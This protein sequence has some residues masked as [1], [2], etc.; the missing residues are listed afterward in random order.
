MIQDIGAHKFDLT[1]GQPEAQDHDYVLYMKNNQTLLRKK[2]DSSY[3]IPCF[4]DFPNEKAELKANAYYFCSKIILA[5]ESIE[6][7]PAIRCH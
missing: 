2:A 5:R 1:Y 7:D 3:E 6:A 4:S